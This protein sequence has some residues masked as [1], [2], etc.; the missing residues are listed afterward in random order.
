MG[1]KHESQG[2]GDE[3]ESSSP[4]SRRHWY[5]ILGV[6]G[7]LFPA[8]LALITIVSQFSDVR[9]DV[10]EIADREHALSV[11]VGEL[12]SRTRTIEEKLVSIRMS[13]REIETQFRA[14]DAVRNLSHADELR[15]FS[16]LWLKVFGQPYPVSDAYY[17]KIGQ[18]RESDTEDRR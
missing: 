5:I 15:R 1:K 18:E 3:E 9:S 17:P 11:T 2:G 7:P 13:L 12:D 10:R 4:P 14:S 8:V 6:L 16:V